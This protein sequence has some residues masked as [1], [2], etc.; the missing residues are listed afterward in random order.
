MFGLKLLVNKKYDTCFTG[1]ALYMILL[2]QASEHVFT[3]RKYNFNF[4][5]IYI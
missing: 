3:E 2:N 1:N 4:L 5:N